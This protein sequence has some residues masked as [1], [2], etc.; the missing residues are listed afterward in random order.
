MNFTCNSSLLLGKQRGGQCSSMYFFLSCT[1]S[2]ASTS[3]KSLATWSIK[4]WRQKFI[5]HT[6]NLRIY[7][8][9]ICPYSIVSCKICYSIHA[10]SLVAKLLQSKQRYLPSGCV[11][12]S[13]TF[14]CFY[15]NKNIDKLG[16]SPCFC[17]YIIAYNLLWKL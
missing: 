14:S 15:Q 3:N 8:C 5:R 6:I 7:S 12:G 17:S 1:F 10:I 2:P 16:V 9:I 11:S 13:W 4:L